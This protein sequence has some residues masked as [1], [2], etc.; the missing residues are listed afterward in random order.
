[1][2]PQTV[3]KIRLYMA[4][5]APKPV[6]YIAW[7]FRMM[8]KRIR[9][10]EHKRCFGKLNP[11]KVFY[12]IRLFPPAS[13]FLANYNYVLGYM[14]HAY[15]L[16]YIPVVDMENYGTIYQQK[17]PVNDTNNVW[18]Y[19]F[20]QP[21]DP[22]TNKRY[23]LEEVYNSQNVVLSNAS[24][25]YY[26]NKGDEE[27]L[28]WQREMAERVPFKTDIQQCI[29]EIYHK[30][31][32]GDWCVVA[33]LFR[34]SDLSGRVIGH[35]VQA[36]VDDVIP[37][38]REKATL[39]KYDHVFIKTEEQEIIDKVKSVVPNVLYVESKRISGYDK[40]KPGENAAWANSDLEQIESLL[41]YLTSIY[42]A[43]R[44]QYL[45][46]SMNNGLYTALIWNRGEYQSVY[47]I[48]KGYYT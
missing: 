28:K 42:I 46:G 30:I 48:D 35:A 41:E 47:V 20:E 43:S 29:D 44:C 2:K 38:M 3:E 33:A 14:K 21:I 9:M 8:Y 37:L 16:G 15:D 13:G 23:S 11:D 4:Q 24:M 25:E 27:T 22:L 19:F 10:P 18:E 34:G 32:Q 31:I 36:T 1:M 5:K 12:V 40:G 6:F 7:V 39:W 17:E 45:I 26:S